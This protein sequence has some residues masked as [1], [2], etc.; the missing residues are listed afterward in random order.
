MNDTPMAGMRSASPPRR[1]SH[2]DASR[3][4]RGEK[5]RGGITESSLLTSGAKK[6]SLT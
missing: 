2:F 5:A 3:L 1:H 4:P 6:H